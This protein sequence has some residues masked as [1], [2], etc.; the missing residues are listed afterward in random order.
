MKSYSKKAFFAL[1]FLFSLPSYA[2]LSK[3]KA[4][5]IAFKDMAYPKSIQLYEEVIANSELSASQHQ[6]ALLNLATAYKN[7]LDFANADFA[8]KE[9]FIKY[10]NSLK[11]EDV[12]SYAQVL[13]GMDRK[14]ESQKMYSKYG[15]MQKDD[16]R[17][18]RFS[19]AYMDLDDFYKDSSLYK[20]KYMEGLNTRFPD[21]SPMYYQN[22]LVFVSGRKES[23]GIKRI[24]SQNDTPFL[25][26]FWAKTAEKTPEENVVSQLGAGEESE[27]EEVPI[28]KDDAFSPEN[29][30]EFSSTINSKY[31]EGPFTFFK[32]FKKM[33]FTRNSSRKNKDGVQQLKLFMAIKKGG[34]WGEISELPFNSNEYS[35]G[36][37]AL[38]PDNRRLYFASDMPGG[39]GGTDI[40]VID[41]KDGVWSTPIN[42]GKAVNTEGNELFPFVDAVGDMYFASNGHAGLGGLDIFKIPF[43][44]GLPYGEVQNL[45]SPINSEK[46]DFG[47]I[48][49]RQGM[50]GFFSS[51]RKN[52]TS[53]DNIYAFEKGCKTLDILVYD[54]ENQTPIADV[55]L[56][57]AKDGVNGV[58]YVTNSEGKVTVCL[59]SGHDFSFKTFKEG[60]RTGNISYA[61]LSSSFSK[62][63]EIKMLIDPSLR[64]LI[65]G[66]VISEVSKDPI[67]GATVTLTNELDGSDAQ[68]ITGLDGFYSF[69]PI[70]DGT[71][72]V[73]AV[74]EFHAPETEKLGELKKKSGKNTVNQN[75]GM[76]AEGDI[77]GLDNIYFDRDKSVIRADAKKE[78]DQKVIP[79]L[80]KYP[81]L[82]IELRAHTD[83]RSSGEYNQL[84]SEERSLAVAR[85]LVGKGIR[86]SQL[87]SSG[88][89]E[90]EL[91]NDC[92]D[93]ED[94]DEKLHQKNRRTEFKILSVGGQLLTSK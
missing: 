81:G 57:S 32:G 77:F 47:L 27:G 88:V 19:V 48:A 68:V 69:Q 55:E 33:I 50:N 70:K 44:M 16:L 7:V 9:L 93:T 23:V 92:G 58:S 4:A 38:S 65:T 85:Y 60:Y 78:L 56:R 37:P 1:L 17:A 76:I 49:D 53:D 15:E 82:Q 54:N 36:H 86:P 94:C 87:K 41:Y 28:F 80:Q 20:I 66:K 74:K 83:S 14:R 46:D 72:S 89:G 84:L 10:E 62:R 90:Q 43:R 26:I 64:T 52:G 13:A 79:L 25:D 31:H 12:L 11:P 67:A 71:Y 45:G 63:Q 51:N 22:G 73:S 2:Q 75:F 21:F 6:E 35:C 42:L 30:V 39:Y 29:V 91:V 18:K 5:Q 59:E 8:Y 24:F 40:Y 34:K 61:T 3:L